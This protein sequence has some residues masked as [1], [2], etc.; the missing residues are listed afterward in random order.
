M[1]KKLKK[2][3]INPFNRIK[4]YNIFYFK[5]ILTP[6]SLALF[7]NPLQKDTATTAKNIVNWIFKLS[8]WNDMYFFKRYE[9]NYVFFKHR[10]LCRV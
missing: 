5:K 7:K 6:I 8:D 3:I 10:I 4:D 9:I 2:H 1:Q